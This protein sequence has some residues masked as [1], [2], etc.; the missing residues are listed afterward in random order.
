[1]T[2]PD[3]SYIAVVLDRSG[4]IF[5]IKEDVEGGLNTFIKDQQ[6][7]PGKAD[8]Y[9]TQFDTEYDVVYDGDLQGAPKVTVVPRDMTA[10]LDAIAKTIVV[11]GE[12]LAAKDEADRPGHVIFVISTDGLENASKEFSLYQG[13]REKIFKMITTQR[14]QF[15]WEFIFLAANQD[16]IAVGGSYGVPQASSLTFDPTS[17]GVRSSYASASTYTTNLRGGGPVKGF[18]AEDRNKA[19][20][21]K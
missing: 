14:E 3:Y 19:K 5:S 15:G 8:L 11:V 2:N 21:N 16:A 18:T 7:V 12:K 13:G 17:K 6:E 4:S 9:L 20:S 1:M 10:L